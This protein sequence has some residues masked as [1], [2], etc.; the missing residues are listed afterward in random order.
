M[1]DE[2]KPNELR[3][4]IDI[5]KLDFDKLD[6]VEPLETIIGQE[7]AIKSLSFGVGNKAF[8]YNIYVSGH[9]G[10]EKLT[11]VKNFIEE[12]ARH[13]PSPPDWCYVNNFK[14]EYYPRCLKLPKGK[15][16]E[17]KKDMENFIQHVQRSINQS[18]GSEE[19]LE[20]QEKLKKEGDEQ[21]NEAFNELNQMAKQEKFVIQ[22]SMFGVSAV[23][24]NNEGTPISNEDFEKLSQKQQ[25]E[26][27]KNQ[28]EIRDH[29]KSTLRKIRSIDVNIDKKI[30][31]LNNKIVLHAIEPIVDDIKEKYRDKKEISLYLDEVKDDIIEHHSDFLD[32]ERQQDGINPPQMQKQQEGFKN[33]FFTRYLVNVLVDNSETEGAPLVIELNPTYNNLFGKVEKEAQMGT[34][35]TN[36][37]LI[38]T[39][40]LQKSNGGYLLLPVEEL[41]RNPFSWDSLKKALISREIRIEELGEKYGFLSTKSLRPHPIPLNLQIILIGSPEIYQ[42]LYLYDSDFRNLFKIKAEFDTNMKLNEENIK[43]YATF[44]SKVQKEENLYPFDNSALAKIVEYGIRLADDKDKLSA[45][46]SDIY[47]IIVESDYYGK[48]NGNV[49]I[50]A[51]DVQRALEEKIY[52]SNLIQEKII[53]MIGNNTIYID[54]EGEKT[55]QVNGLAVL[56]LQDITFGRPSRITATVGVGG[57]GIVDIEREAKL[58]GNIHTKGVMI[59]S[60]FLSQRY[61]QNNPISLSARIVFEQS[62]SYIEGD[63]ASCAEL[64]ALLSELSGLP[65]KQY[66]AVTGSVNQK[67]EVQAVGGINEKI[68]GYFEICKYKGLYGNQGVIIPGSNIR[69]L[70]LKEEVA[71]AVMEGKFHIWAVNTIDEGIEIL[72]GVKAGNIV[73]GDFEENTVNRKVHDKIVDLAI[74]LRQFN[75]KNNP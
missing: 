31:E 66:I 9:A 30:N 58:G 47:G 64:Y 45:R 14:D 27:I 54:L 49:K 52:R 3:N 69:N 43:N 10:T 74:K 71:K 68:E 12:R 1:I 63:S 5:N 46:F 55:G 22:K 56:D 18:F 32:Q 8:G 7:R 51:N 39:G 37:S 42:L 13:Q 24:V 59:L 25:Q 29:I 34:M 20:Q 50:T 44:V 40:A 16:N 57:D 62:Y 11:A 41:F 36:F 70:I 48:A 61:A 60:G 67:G 35:Y 19:Y 28:E 26:L 23:S 72:T 17:F 15:A 73:D 21:K 2:L 53:E 4:S 38:V 75:A 33:E 6:E 65:I